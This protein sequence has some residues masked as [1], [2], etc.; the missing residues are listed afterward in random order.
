MEKKWIITTTIVFGI[1]IIAGAITGITLYLSNQNNSDPNG[2]EDYVVLLAQELQSIIPEID[3]LEILGNATSAIHERLI[4]AAIEQEGDSSSFTWNVTAYTL[5]FDENLTAIPGTTNFK[6]DIAEIGGKSLK[7]VSG[8]ELQRVFIAR[9]LV[10]EP[11]LLL[12]DEPT[13]SVDT[14]MQTEFYQ[15][16]DR[17]RQNMAIVLV[18]HDIGAVSV[19]V[20]KIACLNRRLFYHDS[21]EISPE[22]LEA[23]YG[24]P[25]DLIAHGVPHRVLRRH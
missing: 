7:E 19:Y 8:G 25:V 11:K 1:L 24:C 5:D 23:V 9:A 18:S 16:L 14:A 6:L 2:E 13:A 17:L 20:D 12:L 21:K 4:W 15:I 3:H 10:L 22:E